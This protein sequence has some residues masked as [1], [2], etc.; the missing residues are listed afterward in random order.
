MIKKV[1]TLKNHITDPSEDLRQEFGEYRLITSQAKK[2]VDFLLKNNTTEI[3]SV[4]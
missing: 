3:I 4:K 1:K 2:D